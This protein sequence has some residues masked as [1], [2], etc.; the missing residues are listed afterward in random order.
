VCELLAVAWDEPMPYTAIH[1]LVCTLE[2]YGLGGFGWGVAWLDDT[3]K[4]AVERGL[5]RYIDEAAERLRQLC[6]E[7]RFI[8]AH[9]Q[10]RE[11]ELEERM[12]SYELRRPVCR[13]A[14]GATAHR[15]V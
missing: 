11:K 10:M 13:A 5:R 15:L 9:G 6:P 4:I 14:V 3:G 1:D 2:I 7:L 12:A 8:V